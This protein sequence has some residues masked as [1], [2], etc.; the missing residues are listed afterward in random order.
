MNRFVIRKLFYHVCSIPLK[1]C[2]KYIK[3]QLKSVPG[4]CGV[5]E[6]MHIFCTSQLYLLAHKFAQDYWIIHWV[7]C[8]KTGILCS[9]EMYSVS[10]TLE[11]TMK[12]KDSLI[13]EQKK[14]LS[15][16]FL[17]QMISVFISS[18]INSFLSFVCHH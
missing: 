9:K 14:N 15:N 4:K 11:K 7:L 5:A 17:E 13:R 1:L 16:S 12:S 6:I 3:I 10:V 2:A 8:Y 18:F